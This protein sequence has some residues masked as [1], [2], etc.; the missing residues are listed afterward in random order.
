MVAQVSSLENL[1]TCYLSV[2][3]TLQIQGHT[4]DKP[5]TNDLYQCDS[6]SEFHVVEEDVH[7]CIFIYILL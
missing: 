2:F 1:T 5:R 6:Q 7:R 4:E 3:H